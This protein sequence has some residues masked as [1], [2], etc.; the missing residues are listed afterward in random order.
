MKRLILITLAVFCLFSYLFTQELRTAAQES[1]PKFVKNPDGSIGGIA[2]VVMRAIEKVDSSIKFVGDQNFVPFRRIEQSI[3]NGSLDV[4]FGFAKNEEREAK[5]V[6][7]NPPIYMVGNAIVVKKADSIEDIKDLSQL[8]GKGIVLTSYGVFQSK[9]LKDAGADVDDSATGLDNN[10]KK[11]IA[12]RGRFLMQSEI[13]LKAAIVSG[14][15]QNEVRV[16]PTLHNLSGRY[17]A[18]SKSVNPD[19]INKVV[20]ALEILEKNGELKTIY[21][22]YDIK[23]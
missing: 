15:Y 6:Y 21:N 22:K 1:E 19:L 2:V 3:E 20:K 14:E 13:E 23:L 11:L 7:V 10:L 18:F 5:Y 9:L 8:A 12:G 16:L 17:I 4:F